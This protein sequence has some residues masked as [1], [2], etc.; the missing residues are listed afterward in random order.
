MRPEAD[1]WGSLDLESGVSWMSPEPQVVEVHV[2]SADDDVGDVEGERS[3]PQRRTP[4][5]NLK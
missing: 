5:L 3:L 2:S 1:P 4:E